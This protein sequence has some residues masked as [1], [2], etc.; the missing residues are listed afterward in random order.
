MQSILFLLGIL[1]LISLSLSFYLI[2]QKTKSEELLRQKDDKIVALEKEIITFEAKNNALQETL[3]EKAKNIVEMERQLSLNF[4]NITH[5]LFDKY[6][7]SFIEKSEKNIEGVLSPVKEKF[8]DLKKTLSEKYKDEHDQRIRLENE[9]QNIAKLNIEINE[10]AKNLTNALK[11]NHK[12]QGNWGEFVLERLLEQSSLKKDED[13]F[14]QVNVKDDEGKRQI[15]DVVIALP[16]NKSII[17]DSKV[18]SLDHYNSFIN[19]DNDND[20]QNHLKLFLNAVKNQID[21][22][23]ERRYQDNKSFITPEFVMMFIPIEGAFCLALQSD[24]RLHQYAWDK[25]VVI[26]GPTTLFATLKTVA[27]V[28]R[29]EK[30]NKNT[31]L[32]KDEVT[33]LYD[34][35]V[36]FVNHMENVGKGI[37]NAQKSYDNA[38][39]TL[40]SGHGNILSKAEKIKNIGGLSTK[41]SLKIETDEILMVN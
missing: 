25:K 32:V 38:I 14:L 29:N 12:T 35:I 1:T 4:E 18:P 37:G 24:E 5:K 2:K 17:I 19:C 6:Q 39:K 22:L 28:W 8:E 33:K 20:R 11:S 36:D 13:Y 21:E 27:S 7:S 15:P 16:E 34:R 41:K 31:E 10:N 9:I 23:D 30:I 26:V 40:S 3:S